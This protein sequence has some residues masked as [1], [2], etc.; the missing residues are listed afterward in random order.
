M[1]QELT[2]SGARYDFLD[3]LRVIAIFI[4]L[5]FH[6][7]MV[8]VGWGWHI[9]NAEAIAALELPMDI[10]HRLR[11]PLLFVIAGAGLWFAQRRRGPAQIVR[12]R[13]SRLLLPLVAGM[14]LIVPPQVYM[15]RLFRGQWDGGYIQ[16]LAERVLELEPY[17]EGD[18][19][20]HHLWFVL[21]LYVY[22]MLLLPLIAWL[23][24][25]RLRLKPGAWIAALALP[26]GANEALLKPLFPETHNLVADWWVFNHYLLLTLYGYLLA[27]TGAW[28]W[29]EKTRRRSLGVAAATL[30]G[31]LALFDAGVIHR[32]TPADAVVANVFTWSC[33]LAFLGYG[34][35]Y[36]SFSNR[37][38]AWS[39]EASYPIYIIHQTIIVVL[40]YYVVSQ[41]WTPWTK[42]LVILAA[43]MLACAVA[44]EAL[45][46]R[47]AFTRLIFGMKAMRAPAPT[48]ACEPASAA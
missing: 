40:A 31:A 28:E 2:P 46:R 30:I 48:R 20:W 8:F 3:W 26:L 39:R 24:S 47:F 41:P 5:F 32:D 33:L 37:L 15:E 19:S 4:L 23:R 14:V 12:E 35:R 21:Y 6:T 45:I 9:E 36:L 29:L 38:L 7:G 16:F 11:M 42:Y 44:Y 25:R 1:Q 13:T 17:P 34:R 10:A 43:T 27:A 18:L 22:V